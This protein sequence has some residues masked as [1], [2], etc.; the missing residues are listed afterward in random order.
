MEALSFLLAIIAA[1]LAIIAMREAA[2]VDR[3]LRQ[4]NQRLAA[5][6][7]ELAKQKGQVTAAPVAE[8][9]P[10]PEP[11]AEKIAEAI[12]A[13]P[14]SAAWEE[15]RAPEAPPTPPPK[16]ARDVEGALASRW[17]V[18]VGGAAIA[19]GGLLFV[20]LAI[21]SG[22]FPPLLR[23]AVG[24]FF[25]LALVALAE[26]IRLRRDNVAGPDYIPAALSAGG[27]VIAFGSVYAA[28]ALY[29]LLPP[30]IAFIGLAAL[31]LG[32]IALSLR[33][34]PLIAALG[35]LGS[36]AVPAL[37][38]SDNPSAWTFFPY[39]LAILAASLAV[40]RSRTWWWLGHGAIIGA[41][42]WALLYQQSN[43]FTVADDLPIGLFALS[44]GAL[45]TFLI[46]GRGMLNESAS[47]LGALRTSSGPFKIA[48][49]GLAAMMLVLAALVIFTE[50]MGVALALLLIGAIA[51]LALAA[52]NAGFDLAA[53]AAAVVVLVTLMA[54]RYSAFF[55]IAMDETGVWVPV[56]S[57]EQGRFLFWMLLSAAIFAM[58]G[59]VPIL[60]APRPQIWATLAAGAVVLFGG[61]A[62][63]RA[64]EVLPEH[65][66]TLIAAVVAVALVA[67]AWLLRGR[68]AEPQL[69]RAAG[70]V[71]IAAAAAAAFALDR[72]FDGVWLTLVLAILVGAIALLRRLL[73]ID[74]LG[75]IATAVAALVALRLF[76]S[77]ELWTEQGGLP[78][79][80][81]WLIYGY[82]IPAI[83]FWL[84]S[85]VF[86]AV[87]E[88]R[89]TAALEGGALG[90]AVALVS[91]E[92][93]VLIGGGVTRDEP[94]LLEIAAHASAWLGAAYGLA[95]RQSLFSSFI[96]T[97]G[98]R[99][100]LAAS[101]ILLIGSCLLAKNPVVTELALEGGAVFNPLLLAYLLPAIL[102]TLIATRFDALG[103]HDLKPWAG[104]L[105][106]V[107]LLAYLTLQTKR[108]FQ[109]AIMVPEPLSD[110]ENYAYSA[111][112]LV[113]ALALFIAG[114]R[115]NRQPIRYA[116][117]AVLAL[118]VL[119]VFLWDMSGLGG[120]YR[121]A[122]FM[123]LGLC[124]VGIGWLYTR[125]VQPRGGVNDGRVAEAP[126]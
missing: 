50:H 49:L 37:I 29:Q 19:I 89:T 63:A 47:S 111:V 98:A 70:I 99:I 2:N 42:A 67:Y 36:Y 58:A 54:W 40:L 62:W 113:F 84:A 1:I 64:P 87:G 104:G 75:A 48:A 17:F 66:W 3:R 93:R 117:L 108:L 57:A 92:L 25:G 23:C 114:I 125:F 34:G 71:L 30:L 55:E 88:P 122:S 52:V 76:T 112:W 85:R 124:L 27:L 6:E 81:H 9:K 74:L 116:G 102:I 46:S 121:V 24:V 115:L 60:R 95:Y 103:L 38:S 18:Y 90:L 44:I 118:V 26:F 78:L 86:R 107:L 65:L 119:K 94:G 100:L 96:S 22:W 41:A 106:L 11:V 39:L 15:A 83:V 97:W 43:I 21:D 13:A 79:G 33:Q 4:M 120:L 105:S 73:P 80:D 53:P 5:A 72:Q 77:H 31:G 7:S 59:L 101:V 110:G 12:A 56:P 14:A 8:V 69:N 45:A 123:G 126:G 109:G 16:P 82:G 61:G 28:Y 35:L 51:I 68:L 32:A 10:K 91:L 20:K